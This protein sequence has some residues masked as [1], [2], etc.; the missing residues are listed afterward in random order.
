M[1][2]RPVIDARGE[3]VTMMYRLGEIKAVKDPEG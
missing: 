1:D 3:Y 2:W